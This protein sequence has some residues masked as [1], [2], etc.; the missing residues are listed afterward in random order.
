MRHISPPWFNS[1]SFRQTVLFVNERKHCQPT[2][3]LAHQIGD[4]HCRTPQS[5]LYSEAALSSK[6]DKP[7]Q[8]SFV[9]HLSPSEPPIR[10]QHFNDRKLADHDHVTGYYIEASHDEC[11]RK[12]RVVFDIPVSFHNFRGDDSHLIVTVLSDAAY[13]T[14]KIEVI[15]QNME[16]YIQVKWGS[17]LVFHVLFMFIYQFTRI[18]G[19]ISSQN[20]RKTIQTPRVADEHLLSRLRFKT[21]PTQRRV[22]L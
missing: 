19:S 18:A 15:G 13:W 3:Q 16:R 22:S 8:C 17:N 20:T 4:W 5:K 21:P 7:W 9:L 11:N 14:R 10:S 6:A 12:R 1:P 2:S